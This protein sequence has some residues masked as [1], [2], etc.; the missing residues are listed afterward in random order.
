MV[1][2]FGLNLGPSR[3]LAR[4][5]RAIAVLAD[6]YR[7]QATPPAKQDA[8][9]D[10]RPFA[11]YP[12]GSEFG[13]GMPIG[14]AR[15]GRSRHIFRRFATRARAQEY[16][17]DPQGRAQL[18][19]ERKR[20]R[21]VPC[22]RPDPAAEHPLA[23]DISP[24]RFSRTFRPLRV[25]FGVS[26]TQ[27]ERQNALNMSY[28][29]LIRLAEVLDIP[30]A[31]LFFGQRLALSFGKQGNRAL[32]GAHY[33][34]QPPVIALARRKGWGSVA[35]EWFHALDFWFGRKALEGEA[36][37][38]PVTALAKQE[39]PDRACRRI[40]AL[41]AESE[42]HGRSLQLDMRCDRPYWSLWEE[43]A[44]RVFES[45]I[46]NILR[47]QRRTDDHLVRYIAPENWARRDR[48]GPLSYPYLLEAEA[49]AMERAFLD[50]AQL[51]AQRVA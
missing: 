24:D 4:S 27:A 26:M 28:C 25:Q 8:R 12:M 16:L 23:I 49:E 30:P 44:A 33:S 7:Q 15:T 22:T 41:L 39:I 35:H 36:A 14:N 34:L 21:A 5:P 13:V 11:I 9:C 45:V 50:M 46:A 43:M 2:N 29:A 3:P 20:W 37:P 48:E 18:H 6:K 47:R 19:S 1:A 51:A 31:A 42:F 38:Q 40:K 32:A 10:N 17:L